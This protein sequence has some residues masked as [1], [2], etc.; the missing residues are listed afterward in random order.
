MV[1]LHHIHAC[2]SSLQPQHI[3]GIKNKYPNGLVIWSGLVYPCT[4]LQPHD[5]HMPLHGDIG[6]CILS[7]TC[8]MQAYF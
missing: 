5:L 7:W 8:K 2:L 6:V 4:F 1:N 3:C